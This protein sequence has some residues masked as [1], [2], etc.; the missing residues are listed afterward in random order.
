ML[1]VMKRHD[2]RANWRSPRPAA[3]QLRNYIA[4]NSSG[5]G[6]VPGASARARLLWRASAMR[7]ATTSAP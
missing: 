1:D 7:R 5:A 2:P 6:T 3:N 4:S